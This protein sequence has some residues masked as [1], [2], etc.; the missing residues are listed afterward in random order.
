[1]FYTFDFVGE[2][3]L[4]TREVVGWLVDWHALAVRSQCCQLSSET[5]ELRQ[6]CARARAI[7]SL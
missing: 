7:C 5:L 2:K 6:Q 1:M 4:L 3:D